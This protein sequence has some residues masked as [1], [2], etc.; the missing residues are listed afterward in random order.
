MG[1]RDYREV[2]SSKTKNVRMSQ[3]NKLSKFIMPIVPR[4]TLKP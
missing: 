4:K 1:K 3:E 2:F